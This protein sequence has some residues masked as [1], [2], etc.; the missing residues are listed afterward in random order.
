MRRHG[1]SQSHPVLNQS[2]APKD[3]RNPNKKQ[4]VY[5]SGLAARGI[6]SNAREF[7]TGGKTKC[8]TSICSHADGHLS[9]RWWLASTATHVAEVKRDACCPFVRGRHLRIR[10]YSSPS[11]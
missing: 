6:N 4:H 3:R 11:G 9:F 2:I 10:D 8:S 5:A 1:L 7:V